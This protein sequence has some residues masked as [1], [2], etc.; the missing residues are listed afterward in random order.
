MEFVRL[1]LISVQ[2]GIQS[3]DNAQAAIKD[4]IYPMELVVFLLFILI[5]LMLDVQHGIGIIMYVLNAQTIGYSIAIRF[6]FLSLINAILL[7]IQELVSAVM[8]DTI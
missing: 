5:Q 4:T 3:P 2:L 8:L 7:I 6:A 1:F